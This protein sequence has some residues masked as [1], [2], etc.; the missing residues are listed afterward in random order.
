MFFK[1]LI[2]ICFGIC[3]FNAY[4]QD[5]LNLLPVTSNKDTVILKK[6]T[7]IKPT[8]NLDQRFSLIGS[9]KDVDIW[10]YRIGV[11][12]NNKYKVGLGG[13]NVNINFDSNIAKTRV[14]S[15]NFTKVS[16]VN[17]RIKFGTIYI[18]PYLIRKKLWELGILFEIGYG[19]VLIDSFS[20]VKRYNSTGR[21]LL[22]TDIKTN[23]GKEP[24]VPIGTGLTLNFIIPDI[25]GLHFL[26]YLGINSIIGIRTV[27]VE[28]DFKQNYD[29]FF[30]SI[31]GIVYVDRILGD[32]FKKKKP[33]ASIPK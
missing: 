24:I 26:S 1:G 3:S 31:G 33:I 17:Q 15:N 14:S 22:S 7:S 13:Y 12:I 23:T 6:R 16:Q 9:N 20:V 11:V 19:Q 18:V 4:S 29:G 28:S 30:W 8:A 5:S 10:G 32:L 25:K 2:F 27:I 21:T